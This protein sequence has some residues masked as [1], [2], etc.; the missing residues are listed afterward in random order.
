MPRHVDSPTSTNATKAVLPRPRVLDAETPELSHHAGRHAGTGRS[1]TDGLARGPSRARIANWTNREGGCSSALEVQS[2]VPS[3]S[4]KAAAGGAGPRGSAIGKRRRRRKPVKVSLLCRTPL[5][6]A[7]EHAY[8]RPGFPPCNSS[9]PRG[10][11]RSP[12]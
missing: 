7:L 4:A 9:G 11:R 5:D 1:A 2:T 8:R 6:D 10:R 3:R 12:G